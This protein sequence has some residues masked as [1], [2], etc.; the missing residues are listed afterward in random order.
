MPV[1]AGGGTGMDTG[2]RRYDELMERFQWGEVSEF[3][4]LFGNR[5]G[6]CSREKMLRQALQWQAQ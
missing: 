1:K 6:S 2:F 4:N 5:R 3:M